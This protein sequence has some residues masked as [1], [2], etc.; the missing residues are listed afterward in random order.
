MHVRAEYGVA[1]HWRYKEG[2][3]EELSWMSD[4]RFLQET[5]DD[6]GEFLAGL[7]ID[8][9]R[10]E[11]FVLTPKGDVVTLPRGATSIDFA[12]AIHTEVGHRC[13]GAR[14]N[15]RLV[16]LATELRSG[17]IVEVTTSKA[18]GAGP[19][20]DWLR[21]VTTSR[22]AAKIRQWFNRERREEA[23]GG[24]REQIHKA[25]AKEGLGMSSAERD[26]MLGDVAANLGFSDADAMLIAVGEGNLNPL[27]VV[28]RLARAVRPLEEEEEQDLLRP[29]RRRAR[30]PAPDII[31]EGQDDVWVRIARCCA[32]VPGDDIVGFVTV[33]RGV[34]VHRSDCTNVAAMEEKS[35]RMIDVAWSPHR[36]GS[37]SVWLQIEALDRPRLLRDITSTLSDLGANI[38]ASSSATDKDRVA[39][40]RF[41]VEFSDPGQLK[42]ALADLRGIEA[43]YDAYRLVPTGDE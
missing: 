23:L 37:F 36:A 35:D 9:Y 30:R 12:Y 5:Y 17:D 7:K 27:T 1:A 39:I 6:P 22:A 16:P 26:A 43:V 38:S 24:G 32:P 10:D 2:A 20:R 8:L 33:G 28:G 11:V 13:V 29:P 4:I 41:E 31:V 40:F 34:S 15:G 21:F 25:I 14:V 19:S 42:R 3:P 18:P